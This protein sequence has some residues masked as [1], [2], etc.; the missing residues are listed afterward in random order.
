MPVSVI[1]QNTYHGLVI[2]ICRCDSSSF[3]WWEIWSAD[4]STKLADPKYES[5]PGWTDSLEE[6]AR[7]HV[8]WLSG[9]RDRKPD[10]DLINT[11]D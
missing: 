4:G 7:Q 6:E 5:D 9:N 1:R 2:K 3:E 11:G 8:D 10:I